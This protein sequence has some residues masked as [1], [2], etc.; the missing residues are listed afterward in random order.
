M[1][2]CP[3]DPDLIAAAA[4]RA[5]AYLARRGAG[6]VFPS[7]DAIA[8]LDALPI[9]LPETGLPPSEVLE[10][11]DAVGSPATVH[12]TGGRYFGFVN[13]GTDP[14]ARA[15]A[16]LGGAWD[17]NV[18]LPVMS[19]A[20]A[21]ID[22]IAAGWVRQLLR[23]P[24]TA[25]AAFCSGAS[26]ANLLG[27]VAARDALLHRLGWDVDEKGLAGS[28]PLRIIAG[29]EMHVSLVKALRVAGIG[30][31]ALTFA[32][33]DAWGRVRPER[34]PIADE[35]TIVVLQAGNVN[36]GHSDPFAELIPAVHANGGW[37]HVDGAFG[38]WAAA[39]DRRRHLVEGVELADSWATD[40]HKYLNAP[41]DAG[42]AICARPED[43]KRAMAIDAAYVETDAP[44]ALMHLGLQMSQRARALETWAAIAANG[45]RGVGHL[46][47]ATSDHAARFAFALERGGAEVLAP[48]VL[49]Q[50]LVA[51]GDDATTAAVIEAVQRDGTCWAG[52]TMWQGRKAMRISVSDRATTGDDVD[53]SAAAILR[54]WETVAAR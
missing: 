33:T 8:A 11:L 54:C 42:V 40:A 25:L 45:A 41:Y 38:L 26:V 48:V 12:S 5:A 43:L 9:D 50:A 7:D 37:V 10:L 14:A 28:P 47:D 3:I 18:A 2:R 46:V 13:G 4:N 39:S 22:E 27:V 49:N 17:Q 31:S 35:R 23:L 30:T 53:V 20:A 1:R 24:E 51:F 34:M 15:A 19:P 21:R 52:G 36:T 32:D 44:R 6:P 29:A 16:I